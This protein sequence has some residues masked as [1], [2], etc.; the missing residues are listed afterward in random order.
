MNREMTVDQQKLVEAWQEQLPILLNSGD[1]SQVQADEAD[2]RA[3][4]IHI[5]VEGR[6][7]YSFDFACTY[8]DSREVQV[9]LVDAERDG[10]SV[11]E[12]TDIIQ[13]LVSDYTRHIHQCAQT[14][15]SLTH[16]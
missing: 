12:R 7:M 2:N 8:V 1:K 15:Q 5:E 11:D 3:I 13:Q 14:L 9:S 10:Q 4:R 16:S 6:Q